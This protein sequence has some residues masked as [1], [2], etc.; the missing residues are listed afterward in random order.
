MTRPQV[1]VVDT[2]GPVEIHKRE[3]PINGRE[4]PFYDAVCTRC[5]WRNI[6]W[7]DRTRL[8]TIAAAHAAREEAAAA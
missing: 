5:P 7:R 2:F 8:E 4:T 3:V 1:E 6:G